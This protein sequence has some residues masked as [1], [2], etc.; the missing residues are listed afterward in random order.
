MLPSFSASQLSGGASDGT[1]TP[2][3]F[4]EWVVERHAI[5]KRKNLGVKPPWTMDPILAKYHFCNVYR[6]L[7]AVTDWLRSNWYYPN[8]MRGDLRLT[9]AVIIARHFNHPP[10]LNYLGYPDLDIVNFLLPKR[11]GEWVKAGKKL[12][13]FQAYTRIQHADEGD[14]VVALIK[15][16]RLMWPNIAVGLN[17]SLQLSWKQFQLLPGVGKFMAYEI[18]CDL[19]LTQLLRDAPDRMTWANIG[20]GSRRGLRQVFYVEENFSDALG[21]RMIEHLMKLINNYVNYNGLAMPTLE[22][23]DVEHSLCE[24]DK[25]IRFWET[26]G[27]PHRLYKPGSTV[28]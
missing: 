22:M 10:F 5:Y 24:Y 13:N 25:Y 4:I 3:T 8:E 7:D 17:T 19:K 20:P 16:T 11:V 9:T 28:R 18:V 15:A 23:R 21:V 12:M 6:D 14:R 2:L 26:P 1:P 27:K